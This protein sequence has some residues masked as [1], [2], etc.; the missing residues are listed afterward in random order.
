[1]WMTWWTFDWRDLMTIHIWTVK[2][3]LWHLFEGK[4]FVLFE[5]NKKTTIDL[6]FYCFNACMV[7]IHLHNHPYPVIFAPIFQ[8]LKYNE[9]FHPCQTYHN[10]NKNQ[11]KSGHQFCFISPKPFVF[12]GFI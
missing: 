8:A 12:S 5:Y 7:I 10:Q 2:L 4:I 1:V 11:S 6:V 9:A 3:Y